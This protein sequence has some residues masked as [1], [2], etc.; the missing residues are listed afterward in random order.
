MTGPAGGRRTGSSPN[1]GLRVL[2]Y[3]AALVAGGGAPAAYGVL[4]A[5]SAPE[6]PLRL[7]MLLG[8]SARTVLVG[9]AAAVL[10]PVRGLLVPAVLVA[11][12]VLVGGLLV[13]LLARQTAAARPARRATLSA[14]GPPAATAPAYP[15]TPAP[16]GGRR[17]P[18]GP[19]APVVVVGAITGSLG[20]AWLGGRV[21]TVRGTGE[22]L[23]EG[24]LYVVLARRGEVL[25]VVTA[26]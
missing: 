24:E 21:W 25:E 11:A 1:G 15:A 14:A 26:P 13:R 9:A 19:S 3:A 22:R 17:R 8:W 20:R 16:A 10:G 4:Q 18:V 2:G 7:A 6:P 12:A 5:L 23:R